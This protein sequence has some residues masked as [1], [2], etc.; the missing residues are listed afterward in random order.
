MLIKAYCNYAVFLSEFWGSLIAMD[1]SDAAIS[2][3][4][5]ISQEI[6]AT[7]NCLVKAID[8]ISYGFIGVTNPLGMNLL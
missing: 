6:A 1:W 8:G 2:V 4:T 7:Y 3:V 5:V